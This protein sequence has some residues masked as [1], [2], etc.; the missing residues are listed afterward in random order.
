M[1]MLFFVL[2]GCGKLFFVRKCDVRFESC[3][4]TKRVASVSARTKKEKENEVIR[5]KRP[6]PWIVNSVVK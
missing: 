3:Q 6:T 2:I 5:L 1:S 4:L